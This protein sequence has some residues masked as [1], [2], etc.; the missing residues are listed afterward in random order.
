VEEYDIYRDIA[1]RTQGDI[2]IGVVGPVRTGKSTFIR[3]F[4]ELIVVPNITNSYKK[5]RAKDTLPQ[6]GSGRIITTVEPKFI[7]SDEAVEI[8]LS[9]NAKMRVRMVDC[10]G[11][12][13][14][15]ASG[16]IENGEPRMVK[17]PWFEEEIPFLQAAELGTKK[18]IT[19]HSTIGIVVTTDGSVADIPRESY[20]EAEDKVINEL[21][22]IKKPFIVL[23]NSV[24]PYSAETISIKKELEEKHNVAVYVVDALNMKNEDINNMLEKV[25]YEFPFMEMGINLPEWIEALDYDHW[26]KKNFIM[27]IKSAVKDMERLRDIK[28]M[29]NSL[30]DL[31]F[32]GDVMQDEMKLGEGSAY[33]TMKARDGLFFKV[34][35]EMSGYSLDG[36]YSLLKIMKELSEA[37]KEYDKVA[38][39]LKEVKECGYGLVPPQLDEMKLNEYIIFTGFRKDIKNLF[40][41]SDLYF[42]SSE[43]EASSFLILEVLASGLPV[44]ATDMG[45]N[46]DIINSETNCGILVQYNDAK[47]LAEAILKVMIDKELQKTLRA[48]ALKAIR[49]KFNLDKMVAETYNLYKASCKKV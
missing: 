40:N 15:G 10:V 34:L 47:G 3:R 28:P 17:T 45:G 18:V 49:E 42:N 41:G 20:I 21:K 7:P 36:E 31:E 29:L 48:N 9:D 11:Y 1:E 44:I 22:G 33:V 14:E 25:L 38:G 23:L 4:M 46:G 12:M 43:H 24:H 27:S 13:V 19:E 6:S 2:Y 35:G 30:R 16:H 8:E 39:A 37:K 26:L 5:E 32:I